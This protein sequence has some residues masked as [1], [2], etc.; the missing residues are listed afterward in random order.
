MHKV[1]ILIVCFLEKK[2]EKKIEKKTTTT[3]KQ[4]TAGDNKSMK[5]YP[6]CRIALL[7]VFLN[8]F[9][10]KV[11]FETRGPEGPEVCT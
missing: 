7:L 3:Y 1:D 4:T 2:N 6:V 8:F 5:T 11:D 9:M 10:K